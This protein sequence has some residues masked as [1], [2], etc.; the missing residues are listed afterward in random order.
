MKQA[1]LTR[2][3]IRFRNKKFGKGN[4]RIAY[5]TD[6]HDASGRE[7]LDHTL[8]LLQEAKP[9][10]V[11]SG[12]DMLTAH[13]GRS[14]EKSVAFMTELSSSW[15]VYSALGNHEYRARIYP[16]DYG[17]LYRDYMEPVRKAGVTFLD[18]DHLDLNAG[19]IP[20]RLYGLSLPRK[21]YRRLTRTELSIEEINKLL[22][23]PQPDR[24]N[25]L[26]AHNP[27]YL[28]SYIRWGADLT[29][30]GHY[31]G[32]IVRIDEHKGLIAPD[33]ELMSPRCCG[34]YSKDNRH[35]LI[36]AGMGEHTIPVRIHNPREI[37]LADVSWS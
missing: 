30:C 35:V 19:G 31:H 17:S 23:R 11:L 8:R 34:H 32:G 33:F 1:V 26:L 20:V 2:Y 22:G 12:G 37:V 25:L 13:P 4:F 7:E 15:K 10:L 6:L 27:R 28:E 3:R 14:P 21:Y 16:E 29:L 5:L 36:S 18:N 24:M 9:D